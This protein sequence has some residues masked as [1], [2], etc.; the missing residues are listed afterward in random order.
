MIHRKPLTA[1]LF[2]APAL[3]IYLLIVAYPLFQG[4]SLSLTD[5]KV[6]NAGHF[7][8]AA[9]YAKLATDGDVVRALGI[10][11]VYAA[12]VVVVQ[13]GIGLLLARALY[14]RPRVRRLGN[15]LVLVPTLMSAVMAAFI[16]NSLLSPDGSINS[17]LRAAGL[18]ALTR[19]W[20]GD[21]ATALW[22][23]ALVNIWMFA[24][25][26]A[27]IFLAGYMNLPSDLLDA[28]RVDGASGW[29]RF[30][31]V[32]WPLLAPAL[33]VNI[34]LSL[35]GS[36]KVFELPLVMTNGGPAGSTTTLTML[37]FFKIF[38][39]QGSFAYG[40]TIAT[41]LLVVVVVLASTTQ[42]LLRRREDRI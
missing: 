20:L 3:A 17:L 39:G 22:A 6:G 11:V 8:G 21:P 37:I 38:G 25:Y 30:T 14:N 23:I 15:A 33:T 36:L 40:A 34:T 35:I 32:E 27:S 26:S 19:V 28:A 16:W 13:N 29:Q 12:V 10:T 41:L 24:G 4:I 7:V 2:L 1:A 31:A 5:S 42:A 9:N 18:D